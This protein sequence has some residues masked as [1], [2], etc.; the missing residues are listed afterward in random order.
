MEGMEAEL[1]AARIQ[2][3]RLAVAIVPH[4]AVNRKRTD[5]LS[6]ARQLCAVL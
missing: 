5:T 4:V 2:N 3:A 6:A 1:Y